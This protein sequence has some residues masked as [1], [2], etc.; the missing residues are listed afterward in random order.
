M[1]CDPMQGLGEW[2]VMDAILGR[3]CLPADLKVVSNT[4]ELQRLG[5]LSQLGIVKRVRS[6]ACARVPASRPTT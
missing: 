1:A 3:G 5:Q 2:E 6:S 4:P